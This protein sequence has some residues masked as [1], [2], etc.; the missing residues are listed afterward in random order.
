M[1]EFVDLTN[2]QDVFE[3]LF[4]LLDGCEMGLKDAVDMRNE[5]LSERNW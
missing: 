3:G 5:L 2:L 4:N 1:P